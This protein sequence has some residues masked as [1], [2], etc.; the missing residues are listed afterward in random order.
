MAHQGV[1]SFSVASSLGVHEQNDQEN[2]D[3]T[4]G[5]VC[6]RVFFGTVVALVLFMRG[7]VFLGKSMGNHPMLRVRIRIPFETKKFS[8]RIWS[9]IFFGPKGRGEAGHHGLHVQRPGLSRRRNADASSRKHSC[10]VAG[11]SMATSEHRFLI[12]YI[13]SMHRC[14]EFVTQSKALGPGRWTRS[15][16]ATKETII[17]TST[18][19]GTLQGE[20]IPKSG[21]LSQPQ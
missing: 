12:N 15:A 5:C 8:E 13:N 10:G 9:S 21:F 14:R 17:E 4:T 19:V 7:D 1:P 20:S 6:V 18:C 11:D 3:G 16:K 2:F